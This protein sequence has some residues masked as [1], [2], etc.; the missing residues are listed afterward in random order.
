LKF[1]LVEEG[2]IILSNGRVR[3]PEGLT[4]SKGRHWFSSCVI[5]NS[6]V[7]C[8]CNKKIFCLKIN[9]H[10]L[11]K[12]MKNNFGSRAVLVGGNMFKYKVLFP[13]GGYSA[14]D[15]INLVVNKG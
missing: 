10:P 3:T 2:G 4:C 8:D 1:F 9:E 13:Y 7:T 12:K 5:R 6:K 15:D 14:G 11:C